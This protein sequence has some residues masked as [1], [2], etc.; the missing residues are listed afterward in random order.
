ML[1]ENGKFS[2]I[3]RYLKSITK[4]ST[5]PSEIFLVKKTLKKLN[6][7]IYIFNQF[8]QET[9]TLGKQNDKKTFMNSIN[10]TID[11]IEDAL[12]ELDVNKANGPDKIGNALL[13]SLSKSLPKSLHLL[14]NVIANKAIFPKNGRSAK[15][16]Q[17]S[18]TQS[19]I[20]PLHQTNTVLGPN[21]RR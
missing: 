6:C 2:E 3:Q 18:K 14:F 1:F 21:D 11:E 15:S 19:S 4:S 20:Q 13:K 12:N 9:P 17:F 7:L 10:Y 16:H 8:S 5:I